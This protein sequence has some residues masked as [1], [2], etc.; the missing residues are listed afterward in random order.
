MK[1]LGSWS[2]NI[3]LSHKGYM[4]GYY[5]LHTAGVTGFHRFLSKVGDR[6]MKMQI[7]RMD[8]N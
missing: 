7:L 2:G 4:L 8:L 5:D 6:L 1:E 3:R